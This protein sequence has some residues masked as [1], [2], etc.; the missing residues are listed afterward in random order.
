MKEY[1]YEI[2]HSWERQRE[3]V[4]LN[5]QHQHQR[6]SHRHHRCQRARKD[7]IAMD[8]DASSISGKFI[9]FIFRC[10]I[11]YLYKA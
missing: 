5:N 9:Q 3:P 1:T 4:V 7:E 11:A 2:E 6:H 8:A 10:A